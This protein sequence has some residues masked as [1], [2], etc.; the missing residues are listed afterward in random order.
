MSRQ[1]G[2][3]LVE[4]AITVGILVLAL[5]LLLAVFGL[6]LRH[7]T[8]SRNAVLAK[9]EAEN[10][11]EEVLAHPYGSPAPAT[12]A[13]TQPLVVVE[14]RRVETALATQVEVA[15]DLGGNGSLL[16]EGPGD[17]DVVRIR[18]RWKE[19]RGRG[20]V[21]EELTV[22]LTVRRENGLGAP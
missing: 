15:R 8:Q 12:W 21:E 9:M 3:S 1:S 14:G 22:P 18:V 7:G 6:S 5:L 20:Q 13:G 16:G 17:V 4:A 19:P 2:F 11:I 10:M